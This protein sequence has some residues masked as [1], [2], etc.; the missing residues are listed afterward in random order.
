[1]VHGAP[2]LMRAFI[3]PPLLVAALITASSATIR[4][5]ASKS[6]AADA[7][8]SEPAEASEPMSVFEEAEIR[9]EAA[10]AKNRP[11]RTL[12]RPKTKKEPSFVENASRTTGHAAAKHAGND[13]NAAT[14]AM[15]VPVSVAKDVAE[16]EKDDN[17]KRA[18]KVLEKD[19]RPTQPQTCNSAADNTREVYNN[20]SGVNQSWNTGSD[21][22]T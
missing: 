13:A 19:G 11:K 5:D 17:Y 9:A 12:P 7:K 20:Y 22:G 21:S 16:E 1:M 15:T 8:A 18:K 2:I 3:V 4:P 14:H 10:A 6:D